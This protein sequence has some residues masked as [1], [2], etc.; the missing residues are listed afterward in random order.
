MN[1]F[2]IP[3]PGF[4]SIAFVAQPMR[5][6]ARAEPGDTYQEAVASSP[7]T[8]RTSSTLTTSLFSAKTASSSSAASTLTQSP[9]ATPSSSAR[10]T[11]NARCGY[12]YN[13]A[14]GGMSCQGSKYGNCCSQ[15]SYCGSTQDYCG[16]GCQPGF[17]SCNALSSSIVKLSTSS[18]RTT[19]SGASVVSTSRISLTSKSSSISSSQESQSKLSSSSVASSFTSSILRSSSSTA[20]SRSVSSTYTASTTPSLSSRSSSSSSPPSVMS[21]SSSR[22]SSSFTSTFS[23]SSSTSPSLFSLSPSPSP[24]S[25]CTRK[26]ALENGSF[27]SGEVAPWSFRSNSDPVPG[28]AQGAGHGDSTYFSFSNQRA[29]NPPFALYQWFTIPEATEVRC[30]AWVKLIQTESGVPN[31]VKGFKLNLGNS[32]LD[33][34]ELTLTEV[35]DWVQV[36][37]VIADQKVGPGLEQLVLTVTQTSYGGKVVI[38]ID[39]LFLGK[40]SGADFNNC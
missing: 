10:L 32:G 38:I 1:R 5:T 18:S 24:S 2:L 37:G 29:G 19:S 40:A 27:Q 3:H 21:S 33:C 8:K 31:P 30:S 34:G 23:S 35:G 12:L 14:P 7:S 28:V 22:L 6:A 36:T 4:C 17:G 9:V 15:W 13:A 20:S 16:S 26:N 11:T 39:D 25:T